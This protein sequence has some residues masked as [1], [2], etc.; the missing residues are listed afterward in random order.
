MVKYSIETLI[1]TYREELETGTYNY[2]MISRE[3]I[4]NLTIDPKKYLLNED[5]NKLEKINVNELID[6]FIELIINYIESEHEK[7]PKDYEEIERYILLSVVDDAWMEHIDTMDDLKNGIGLRGYGQR[8]PVIQYKIEGSELFDEM[9]LQIKLQFTKMLTH[10][11]KVE[12]Q[13]LDK[14]QKI[15]ITSASQ[16]E[17]KLPEEK[18]INNPKIEKA[19]PIVNTDKKVGRNNPCPCGSGKKYKNCCGK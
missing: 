4:N 7:H 12:D 15:Q 5:G 3:I 6:T 13:K 19:Q 10:V 11:K 16:E 17:L 1:N 2:D 14:K 8:D 18:Q 9:N